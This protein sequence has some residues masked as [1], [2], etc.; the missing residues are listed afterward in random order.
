VPR[1][2]S[3]PLFPPSISTYLVGNL[4]TFI[5][6]LWAFFF[7][8]EQI[9]VF[10]FLCKRWDFILLRTE[11]RTQGL[12]HARLVLCYWATPPTL[13][14]SFINCLLISFAFFSPIEFLVFPS[15]FSWLLYVLGISALCEIC[16][17]YFLS[18]YCLCITLLIFLLYYYIIEY[19]NIILLHSD[20][21]HEDLLLYPGFKG[22]YP[23]VVKFFEAFCL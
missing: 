4:T 17:R 9:D 14:F 8:N 7:F 13:D 6:F 1:D 20:L 3:F 5:C 15:Q 12:T 21:N 2:V 16:G 23:H 22:T 11:D 10:I 19:V 18:D